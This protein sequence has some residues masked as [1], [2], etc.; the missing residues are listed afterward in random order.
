MPEQLSDEEIRQLVQEAITQTG[1]SSMKEFGKVMVQL[2]L[3]SKEKQ[4]ETK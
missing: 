2:C 4:M 3:K 1:A